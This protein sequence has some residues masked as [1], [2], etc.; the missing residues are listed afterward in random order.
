MKKIVLVDRESAYMDVI[1]LKPDEED[2]MDDTDSDETIDLQDWEKMEKIIKK[3]YPNIQLIGEDLDFRY[4][5]FLCEDFCI[6]D[7][8]SEEPVYVIK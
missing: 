2:F 8:G 5:Y 7:E 6:Y 4:D 1:R 3:R